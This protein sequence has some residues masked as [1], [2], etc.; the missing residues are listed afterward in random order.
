MGCDGGVVRILA[1]DLLVDRRPDP[2]RPGVRETDRARR[3][4][5]SRST[6]AANS[7][8]MDSSRVSGVT[9]DVTVG[10]TVVVVG[11]LAR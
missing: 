9:V 11:V 3:A 7:R 4:E 10:V 1:G 5:R 2:G 6:D 8:L